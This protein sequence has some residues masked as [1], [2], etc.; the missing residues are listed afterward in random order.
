MQKVC[1]HIPPAYSPY[2]LEATAAQE[3]FDMSFGL[4]ETVSTI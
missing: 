4:M 1:G 3:V 2:G